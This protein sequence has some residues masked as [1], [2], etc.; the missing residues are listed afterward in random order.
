MTLHIYADSAGASLLMGLEPDLL[1]QLAPAFQKFRAATGVRL[2][3]Y[4]DASLGPNHLVL[5]QRLLRDVTVEPVS[6]QAAYSAL[7]ALIERAV[8]AGDTLRFLGE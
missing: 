3:E 4:D 5:L 6:A 2:S 1:E 7:T 8:S